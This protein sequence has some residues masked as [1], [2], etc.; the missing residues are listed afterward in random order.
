MAMAPS[1]VAKAHHRSITNPEEGL[2]GPTWPAC[3]LR[4]L[5]RFN[6]CDFLLWGDPADTRIGSYVPMNCS[7]GTRLERVWLAGSRAI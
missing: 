2:T 4:S 7:D 3:L 1:H 6:Y 5:S